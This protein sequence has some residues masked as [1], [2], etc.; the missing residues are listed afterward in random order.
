[1]GLMKKLP[2]TLTRKSLLTMYKFFVR[3]DV[4]Y[5]DII[6]DKPFNESFKRKNEMI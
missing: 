2:S 4:D 3:P 5:V 1:M 6:R